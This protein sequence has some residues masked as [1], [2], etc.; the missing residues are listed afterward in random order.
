MAVVGLLD[1]SHLSLHGVSNLQGTF[2]ELAFRFNTCHYLLPLPSTNKAPSRA[3]LSEET[4]LPQM[5]CL[6]KG[7]SHRAASA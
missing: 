1:D 2:L 7:M 3:S 6:W 4:D 5:P